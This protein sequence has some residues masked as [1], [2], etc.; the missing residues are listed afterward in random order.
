LNSPYFS[1]DQRKTKIN[2]PTVPVVKKSVL[3]RA[4]MDCVKARDGLKR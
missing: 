4:C 2:R 3:L 1:A